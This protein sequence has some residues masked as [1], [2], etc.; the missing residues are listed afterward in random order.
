MANG[1][2]NPSGLKR[3]ANFQRNVLLVVNSLE[4]GG[5]KWNLK[6]SLAGSHKTP[7][8][9]VDGQ[10][11]DTTSNSFDRSAWGIISK[12]SELFESHFLALVGASL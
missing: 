11:I 7:S 2:M 4:S 12:T 10:G 1:A 9:F 6:L 3:S 8:V 5:T